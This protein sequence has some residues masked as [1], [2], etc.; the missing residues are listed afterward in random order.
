M[1]A[2]VSVEGVALVFTASDR[3]LAAESTRVSVRVA[4]TSEWRALAAVQLAGEE[5]EVRFRSELG[6]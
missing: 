4:G 6:A 2:A 1:L 5:G 3:A